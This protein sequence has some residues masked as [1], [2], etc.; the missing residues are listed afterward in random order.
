V[1]SVVFRLVDGKAVATPVVVGPSDE[2]HTLIK[3]GLDDGAEVIAG[4]FK[5]LDTLQ[6]DQKVTKQASPAT[7][8]STTKPTTA[9]AT[10]TA[11]STLPTTRGS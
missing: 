8:Q 2:T 4:P 7:T 9:P 5:V 1:A 10:T 11:P 6:H 3:Q